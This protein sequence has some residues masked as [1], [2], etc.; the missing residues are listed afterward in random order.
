[1]VLAHNELGPDVTHIGKEF[2][3]SLAL[4]LLDPKRLGQANQFPG[5]FGVF[6]RQFIGI[7]IGIN[8]CHVSPL[9]VVRGNCSGTVQRVLVPWF[10]NQT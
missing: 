9:S 7:N 1:M 10:H 5:S 4:Q 6:F 3:L 2:L 8:R